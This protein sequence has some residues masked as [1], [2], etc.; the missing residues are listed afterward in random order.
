MRPPPEYHALQA[1]RRRETTAAF[2]AMYAT[3]AGIE[4]TLSRGIRRCRMR[5]TRY[6]GLPKTR[7]AHVLTAVALNIVRLGEWFTGQPRAVTRRSRFSLLLA[8]QL[9]S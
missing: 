5:R 3:R 1:A 4:G 2:A 9:A 7:L 6:I 8:D